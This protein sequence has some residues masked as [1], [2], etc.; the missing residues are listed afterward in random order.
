[1]QG[2]RGC[3]DSR[4]GMYV[5][6][7]GPRIANAEW[8]PVGEFLKKHRHPWWSKE[9]EKALQSGGHAGMELFC[10]R[11]FV[12]MIRYDREPW[13][14][15]YDAATYGAITSCSQMSIDRKGG[16]VEIPDFTKGKWKDPDWRKDR[17][18]PASVISA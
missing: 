6:G 1:M 3:Y 8:R 9:G 13:V 2:L 10:F 17:P 18:G 15:C 12:D 4:T 11:D 5:R 14:D 7:N 16:P